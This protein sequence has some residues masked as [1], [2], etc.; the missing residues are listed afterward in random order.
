MLLPYFSWYPVLT[1]HRSSTGEAALAA[2]LSPKSIE[3]SS[4]LPGH[5]LLTGTDALLFSLVAISYVHEMKG[6]TGFLGIVM[7]H[8]LLQALPKAHIH[9]LLRARDGQDGLVRLRWVLPDV[10][11]FIIWN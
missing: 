7:L 9:C 3:Q 1:A 5:V 4:E 6:C 2:D 11:N 10:W 8:E